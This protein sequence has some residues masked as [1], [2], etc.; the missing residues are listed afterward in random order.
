MMQHAFI[1]IS[2]TLYIQCDFV[3]QIVDR[4]SNDLIEENAEKKINNNWHN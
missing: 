3:M 1:H 4:V 2:F